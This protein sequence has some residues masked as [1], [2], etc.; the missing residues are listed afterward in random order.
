LAVLELA[1]CADDPQVEVELLNPSA[2]Q[3]QLSKIQWQKEVKLK[4]NQIVL[5][6]ALPQGLR[7]LQI[8]NLK[9]ALS[10]PQLQV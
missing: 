8:R 4:L 7:R 2:I 5:P 9:H 1:L 3:L 6:S 10:T